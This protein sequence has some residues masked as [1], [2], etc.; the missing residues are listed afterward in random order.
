MMIME[1]DERLMEQVRDDVPGAFEELLERYQNRIV[2]ATNGLVGSAKAAEDLAQ[3][4]FTH[5]W[6]SRKKYVPNS[7]FSTWLDTIVR[8]TYL[9]KLADDLIRV[10]RPRTV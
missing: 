4:V 6:R 9:D 5:L 8:I 2:G 10:N 7:K 3:E 1:S